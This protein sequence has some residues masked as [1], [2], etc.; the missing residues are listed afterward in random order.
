[1]S[2]STARRALILLGS[3]AGACAIAVPA[4]LGLSH[5]PSFSQRIPVRAPAAA[6]VA[7]AHHD[8]HTAEVVHRH[9]RK[10]HRGEPPKHE[11]TATTHREPTE[12][13]TP[14]PVRTREAEPGDD[15]DR[16]TTEPGDD[17][18]R[19]TTEPGDDDHGGHGGS[20]GSGGS[21]GDH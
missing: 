17:R 16:P 11:R 8:A 5:N 4:A 6:Q 9:N 7:A 1:M 15:R 18:G 14:S 19:P 20:G 10:H 2:H 3:A 21:G 12:H 13:A